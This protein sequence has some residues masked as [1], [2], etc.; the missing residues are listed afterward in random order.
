MPQLEDRVSDMVPESQRQTCK[1]CGK[2]DKFNF[3]V[4]DE[5]WTAVVPEPLQC[6][7]VCLECFDGFATDRGVSYADSISE[8]YFVGDRAILDLRVA[9]ATDPEAGRASNLK[10]VRFA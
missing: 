5:V 9:S 6:R 2:R 4:P 8:I 7:V 1:A 3:Y 10:R